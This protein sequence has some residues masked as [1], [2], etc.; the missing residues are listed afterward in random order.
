MPNSNFKHF[1]CYYF[2]HHTTRFKTL[3]AIV[4]CGFISFNIQSKFHGILLNATL[5][6]IL[7]TMKIGIWLTNQTKTEIIKIIHSEILR[8]LQHFLLLPIPNH[9]F[10]FRKKKW[11]EKNSKWSD[12]MLMRRLFSIKNL[13][14]KWKSEQKNTNILFTAFL[15]FQFYFPPSTPQTIN[16]FPHKNIATL[17]NVEK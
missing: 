1:A 11:N 8:L 15:M 9:S 13:K 6:S 4:T 17:T 12:F 7:F 14:A 16:V 2:M 3:L 10:D 5:I